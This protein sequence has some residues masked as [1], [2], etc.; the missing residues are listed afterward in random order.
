ML[1]GYLD[2]KRSDEITK[3]N[4]T[5]ALSLFPKSATHEFSYLAYSQTNTSQPINQLTAAKR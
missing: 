1:C 2:G 5:S 3:D 4:Q